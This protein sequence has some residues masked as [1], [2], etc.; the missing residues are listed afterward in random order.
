MLL[1]G[2]LMAPSVV[3][4]ATQEG[5]GIISVYGIQIAAANYQ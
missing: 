3:S 4:V 5:G 2:A 1:G